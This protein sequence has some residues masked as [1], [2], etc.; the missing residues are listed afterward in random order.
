[1]CMSFL[2][3]LL[4]VVGFNVGRLNKNSASLRSFYLEILKELT[5]A[6]FF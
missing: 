3:G 1:M 4:C 6:H 5:F 2:T